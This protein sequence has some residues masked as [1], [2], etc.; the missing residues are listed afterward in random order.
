MD[1]CNPPVQRTEISASLW[2]SDLVPAQSSCSVLLPIT[3]PAV[4]TSGYLPAYRSTIT[5][6]KFPALPAVESHT[7]YPL[8]TDTHAAHSARPASRYPRFRGL[9][10]SSLPCVT[11]SVP[12]TCRHTRPLSHSCGRYSLHTVTSSAYTFPAKLADNSQANTRWYRLFFKAL[13]P[14]NSIPISVSCPP[15]QQRCLYPSILT[16]APLHYSAAI[17]GSH[18]PDLIPTSLV[19]VVTHPQIYTLLSSP[20]DR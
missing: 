15:N 9:P 17:G 10:S 13:S 5:S 6:L 3:K 2:A 7:G 16:P 1:Y 20:I 12:A 19:P 14:A 11:Q 18:N 8:L 4:R